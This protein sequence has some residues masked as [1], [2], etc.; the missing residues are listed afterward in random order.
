MTDRIRILYL[1]DEEQ[2]LFS[3]QALFRREYEVFT[4]SSVQEA[5]EYLNRE[6]VAIIFSDQKMPD[7]SGVE[8]FE[9]IIHQFPDPVRILITGYADMEAV[10]DSINRGQVYRYVTKPW[11]VNELKICVENALEKYYRAA[12]IK[13]KNKE[14][15]KANAELERFIYSA[16]HDLRAPVASIQGVLQVAKMEVTDP[17][18]IGYFEMIEKSTHS[19]NEFIGNIIHYYQNTR[20]DEMIKKIDLNELIEESIKKC[21]AFSH[22]EKIIFKTEISQSTDFV[23]DDQRLRMVLNNIVNNA[24]KFRDE[25]KNEQLVSIQVISNQDKAKFVIS[26]NGLAITQD[27]LPLIFDMVDESGSNTASS[28]IGLYIAREA[29]KKLNGNIS[30]T[31]N[32]DEGSR[33]VFEVPNKS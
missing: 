7:I 9:S 21:Q 15:E 6:E 23:A 3:F 24:V 14:L 31:S 25:S 17:K 8:F 30:V 1:D 4:T 33:F 22:C 11:D 10:I 18:A 28:G 13:T 19:L 26:D 2:N 20:D 12:E 32:I 29:L 27:K 5:I 16:S